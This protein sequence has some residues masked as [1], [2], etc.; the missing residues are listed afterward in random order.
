[1][2]GAGGWGISTLGLDRFSLGIV[3]LGWDGMGCDAMGGG[4]GILFFRKGKPKKIYTLEKK[5]PPFF[6]SSCQEHLCKSS[7][8]ERKM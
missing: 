3:F 6:F 8:S 2:G 1:M 4:K 5:I 7:L